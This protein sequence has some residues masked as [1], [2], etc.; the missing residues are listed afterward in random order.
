MQDQNA[1]ASLHSS[2]REQKKLWRKAIK[3]PLYSVAVM[4]VLL[5]AGWKLGNGEII[6]F[7]QF[8]GFLVASILLLIWENLTNDLFDAETGVD[9]FKFHSVV[10]LTGRKKLVRN[11]AYFTLLLGLVMMSILA[12]KSD[13]SVLLLVLGSCI[14]GYLY[15]GPPFRLGY[16]GLGE[17]LCWIA[18][19]PFAT[20]AALLVLSP[21][22]SNQASIPWITATILG[23]GPALATSL[24]L[25]CAQF[26]QVK[27]DAKHGKRTLLVR[28]G[29]KQA[30]TLVPWIIIVSLIVEW[31]PIF[32]GHFPITALFSAIAL[33]SAISLIRL[34]KENHNNQLLLS[35]SKFLALR[36]Q[37]LNGLGLSLG[38]AIAHPLGIHL[39]NSL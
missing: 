25:F 36:F 17:S 10:A 6:R 30:A 29:T 7:D 23:A 16:Q 14:L 31:I 24:V 33:P 9:E 37:T 26:H 39:A 20:A 21:N 4:P 5:A 22:T 27:E 28:L 35:E 34:L 18:F 3:W 13:P 15:Q 1:V 19:G 12:M 8:I 2:K 11:V 32:L 38:I